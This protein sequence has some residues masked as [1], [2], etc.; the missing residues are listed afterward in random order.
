MLYGANK[1]RKKRVWNGFW[2]C[3]WKAGQSVGQFVDDTCPFKC[4]AGL[5]LQG[6]AM[7]CKYLGNLPSAVSAQAM[8]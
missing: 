6:V 5:V 4:L 1:I 8:I 7:D 2:A 3:W